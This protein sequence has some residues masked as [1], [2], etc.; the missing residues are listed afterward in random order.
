MVKFKNWLVSTDAIAPTVFLIML[1]VLVFVSL[2]GWLLDR[3]EGTFSGSAPS[4]EAIM[5]GLLPHSSRHHED[6]GHGWYTFTL[7][8]R[9]FL[10]Y[11]YG[12]AS[13]LVELEE[14]SNGR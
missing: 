14:A 13:A 12:G 10:F 1:F 2:G 3:A 5:L 11:K 7:D 8:G 9:K 4:K 6:L